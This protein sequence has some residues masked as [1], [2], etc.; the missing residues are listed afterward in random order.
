MGILDLDW[1]H[2]TEVVSGCARGVDRAGE[3]WA[4]DHMIP[5]KHFPADWN[6]HGKAAGPIRNGEMA[7]YADGALLL[8]DGVSRGT[9]NMKEHMERLGKPYVIFT[10]TP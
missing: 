6:R 2:V 7:E 4:A 9:T 8:W 10:V 5:V 1:N 3:I